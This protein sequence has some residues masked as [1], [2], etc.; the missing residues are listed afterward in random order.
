MVLLRFCAKVTDIRLMLRMLALSILFLSF[1]L[2]AQNFQYTEAA[3]ISSPLEHAQ[4]MDQFF[5]D[6]G[7]TPLADPTHG[8]PSLGI[9]QV[10]FNE[11]GQ[12]AMVK[13]GIKGSFPLN[14][15]LKTPEGLVVHNK[16]SDANYFIYFRNL[17]EHRA[18]LLVTKMQSKLTSYSIPSLKNL[19]ISEAHADADCGSPQLISQMKD[20]TNLSGAMVWNFARNC[21]SGLGAG[22]MN[23]GNSIVQGIGNLWSAGVAAVSNPSE[24][25][26]RV[27]RQAYNFTVGLG[28]FVK[29]LVTNPRATMQ[30]IG[31][32]VGGSWNAMVNTVSGMSTEMKIQFI[33][34]FIGSLGVDAA[35]A[36]FT[37]GAGSARVVASLAGMARKFALIS[38]TMNILSRLSASGKARLGMT[39]LKIKNLMNRLMSGRVPDSDLRQFDQLSGVDR[40][41]SIRTMSCYI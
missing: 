35:I 9:N 28:N 7:F 27:G 1:A 25:L 10:Y 32:Q 30:R 2:R 8:I 13:Y 41:F 21:V 14:E 6:E 34:S 12:F 4:K 19:F 3:F 17:N 18:K 22:A 33:C 5:S 37:A 29:G 20:F 31:A 39:S 36:L 11:E 26:D 38:R 23:Q 40:D 16:T 15:F 24:T